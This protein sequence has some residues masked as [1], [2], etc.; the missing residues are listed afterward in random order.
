MPEDH[1]LNTSHALVTGASSGIGAAFADRLARHGHNLILVA[2]RRERLHD[3]AERLQSRHPI[4]IETVVADLSDPASLVAL[5][6][7]ISRQ[8][9][10]DILVNNAGFA[11]GTAITATDVMVLEAMMRVHIVALARL[12]RAALPGMMTRRRGTIINLSSIGA[13]RTVP[14]AVWNM[15]NATKAF[16]NSF[17]QGLSQEV[18]GT[19]IQVQALCPTLVRTEIFE[20]AGLAATPDA[21]TL[22]PEAVVDASLA[23][24]RL[25]EVICIPTL[26]DPSLLTALAELQ[27]SI[28]ARS[29]STNQVAAR[30]TATAETTSRP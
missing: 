12:T 11:A 22:A 17:T 29:I 7:T 1:A 25:Q 13:F 28:V 16:V 8:R 5:E 6:R 26:D 15:Y 20:Q 2:R 23:A 14:E 30:Y 24:L 10:L 27:E 4:A 3:L 19:G 18:R 9:S 21:V